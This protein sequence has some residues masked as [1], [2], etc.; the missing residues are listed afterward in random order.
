VR[1]I[2]R[3]VLLL[4]VKALLYVRYVR[5][6]LSKQLVLGHGDDADLVLYSDIVCLSN[7]LDNEVRPWA[8]P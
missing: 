6:P 3:N 7:A 2:A 1:G 5:R 8:P 4:G